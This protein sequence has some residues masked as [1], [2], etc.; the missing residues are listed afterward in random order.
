[1]LQLI[2][3]SKSY[4]GVVAVEATAGSHRPLSSLDETHL[5]GWTASLNHF[6]LCCLITASIFF[7]TASRL[8]DAGSCIGG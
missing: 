6:P 1:M 3:V 7:F 8:N 2:S 4:R 5:N